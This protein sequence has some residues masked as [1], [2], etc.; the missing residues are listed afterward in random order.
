[1][2]YRVKYKCYWYNTGA[3]DNH[4]YTANEDFEKIDD[5]IRFKNRVNEEYE[6]GK[7]EIL[8][9]KRKLSDYEKKYNTTITWEEHEIW[10]KNFDHIGVENGYITSEASIVKF[11][12]EVEEEIDEREY[13]LGRILK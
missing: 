7:R 9:C 3:A 11:Y 6:M 10:E 5:A 12:P 13:K 1:M 8:S 2:K 4:N